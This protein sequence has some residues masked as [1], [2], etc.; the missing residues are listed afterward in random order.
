M[1][2]TKLLD[3]AQLADIYLFRRDSVAGHTA[4]VMW[5]SLLR[6]NPEPYRSRIFFRAVPA[7]VRD[8]VRALCTANRVRLRK[9]CP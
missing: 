6:L 5:A 7:P 2:E 1:A 3:R 8:A 4:A 9:V